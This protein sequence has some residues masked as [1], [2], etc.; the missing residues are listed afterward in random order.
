MWAL[1][2]ALA[3]LVAALRS[4]SEP[5]RV[6]SQYSVSSPLPY[7]SPQSLISNLRNW[8]RARGGGGGSR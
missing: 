4:I 1:L 8:K 2:A 5:V 6:A 3:T 7:D